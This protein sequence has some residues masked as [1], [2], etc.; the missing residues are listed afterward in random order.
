VE[1][2]GDCVVL[3]VR[4]REGTVLDSGLGAEEET[5]YNYL[6]IYKIYALM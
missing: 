2:A 4:P 3:T 5:E 6:W 1:P